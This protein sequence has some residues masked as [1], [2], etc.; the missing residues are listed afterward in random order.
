MKPESYWEEAGRIGY[1]NQYYVSDTVGSY[2]TGRIWD[3]ALATATRLELNEQ[4]T[5]LDLG[6]GDGAFANSVLAKH[7]KRVD[8]VDLSESGIRRAR[9]N[10]PSK[11]IHFEV[12]NLRKTDFHQFGSYDGVFLIGILHH[13]KSDA[14]RVLSELRRVTSR[15]V[16]MEPNGDHVVRK[17]LEFTPSYRAAGEDSFR[18][19]ELEAIFSQVGFQKVTWRRF[20]L[21]PNFTPLPVFKLLLPLQPYIERSTWLRALCTGNIW[22]LTAAS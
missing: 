14:P 6:C 17:L 1:A 22:G 12:C 11:D 10:A 15:L 21:F 16:V 7:F 3:L 5:V 8:G 20:N 18:T 9:M 2:L 13:V 19:L 4:C